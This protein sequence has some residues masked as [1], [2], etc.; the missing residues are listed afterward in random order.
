MKLDEFQRQHQTGTETIFRF[1]CFDFS[2]RTHFTSFFFRFSIHLFVTRFLLS[3]RRLN[4]KSSHKWASEWM[5]AVE[6]FQLN[7]GE[8]KPYFYG[9]PYATHKHK[10]LEMFL[11]VIYNMQPLHVD[12]SLEHFNGI[13]RMKNHSQIFYERNN[14][15]KRYRSICYVLCCFFFLFFVIFQFVGCVRYGWR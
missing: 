14:N 11:P 1:L 4:L 3:I 9:L 13:I 12:C 15:K 7:N 2:V 10:I 5:S 6:H 8:L